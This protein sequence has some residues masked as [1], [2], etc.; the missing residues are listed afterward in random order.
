M[1]YPLIISLKQHQFNLLWTSDIPLFFAQRHVYTAP[2]TKHIGKS[3]RDLQRDIIE[4]V[5]KVIRETV[6]PHLGKMISSLFVC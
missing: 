4:H 1:T 2:N 6:R 3:I 5:N